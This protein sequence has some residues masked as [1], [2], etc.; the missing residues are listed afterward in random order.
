MLKGINIKHNGYIAY[1]NIGELPEYHRTEFKEWL[2]R[3]GKTQP[4]IEEEA[5]PNNCAYPWDYEQWIAVNWIG[6]A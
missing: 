5:E 3:S 4:I 2:H 6:K 1:I